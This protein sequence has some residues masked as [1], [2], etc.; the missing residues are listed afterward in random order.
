MYMYI[1][2]SLALMELFNFTI[3]FNCLQRSDIAM[4][5]AKNDIFDFLIDIVPREEINSRNRSVSFNNNKDG[6]NSPIII[7]GIQ[8]YPVI[9]IES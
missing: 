8:C 4:A 9:R 1:G 7:I 5:I 6:M 2:H 3:I